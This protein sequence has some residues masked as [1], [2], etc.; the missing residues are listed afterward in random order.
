MS[1]LRIKIGGTVIA[2]SSDEDRGNFSIPDSYQKFL[3]KEETQI[4]LKICHG[5]LPDIDLQE[6]IF[7]TGG[8]ARF[9]RR[10]KRWIVSVSSGLLGGYTYIVADFRNN[11][12][13]GVVHDSRSKSGNGGHPFPL[14]YPLDEILMASLLGAGRGI[15]LHACA[16]MDGEEGYL[17][18]G[19]SGDGKSTLAGLW[20]T[21]EGVKILNDDRVIVRRQAG[22]FFMYGTPWHGSVKE[23]SPQSALLE[24]I[25]IIRHDRENCLRQLDPFEAAKALYVRSFPTF[26]NPKGIN[27]TLKFLEELV[28]AVPCYELGFL[29]EPGVV[30]FVRWKTSL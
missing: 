2:L 6:L 7:D 14:D 17:F 3:T 30:D 1:D 15:L 23:V 25:I 24:K 10:G 26:W 13:S 4:D 19:K 11:F 5:E 9:Y 27:F 22:S 21:E 20:R 18:S 12:C 16:L 29:P 28:Q 8:S